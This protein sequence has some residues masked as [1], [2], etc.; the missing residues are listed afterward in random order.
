MIWRTHSV[1][2]LIEGYLLPRRQTSAG[3]FNPMGGLGFDLLV[4]AVDSGFSGVI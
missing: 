4:E 3:W 2:D 1:F